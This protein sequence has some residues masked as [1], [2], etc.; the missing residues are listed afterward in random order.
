MLDAHARLGAL[1]VRRRENATGVAGVLRELRT[2]RASR[3]VYEIKIDEAPIFSRA[4]HRPFEGDAVI[5]PAG[6]P[7]PQTFL[8]NWKGEREFDPRVEGV[9]FALIFREEPAQHVEGKNFVFVLVKGPHDAAHVDAFEA[10]LKGYG[11]RHARLQRVSF[12]MGSAKFQRQA[13]IS[14]ADLLD[15]HA[16]A[17]GGVHRFHHIGQGILVSGVRFERRVKGA[18]HQRGDATSGVMQIH[19]FFL[20]LVFSSS[21]GRCQWWGR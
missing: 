7:A 15:R 6:E 3:G 20:H 14:T 18:I 16:G 17:I 2:A 9:D 11:A 13:E 12:P 19:R 10:S 21:V 1:G 8:A 5:L 4:I